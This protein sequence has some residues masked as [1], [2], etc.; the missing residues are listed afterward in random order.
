MQDKTDYELASIAICCIEELKRREHD[1]RAM[2]LESANQMFPELR[3]AFEAAGLDM[4]TIDCGRGFIMPP[5]ADTPVIVGV[6]TGYHGN[7][8]K[9]KAGALRIARRFGDGKWMTAGEA[10]M[11]AAGYG[12]VIERAMHKFGFAGKG[13]APPLGYRTPVVRTVMEVAAAAK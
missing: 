4:S 2:N 9:T 5:W 11:F 1:L 7:R 6:N 13:E 8:P 10:W 12:P 3:K